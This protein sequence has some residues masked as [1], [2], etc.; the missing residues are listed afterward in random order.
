MTG[1]LTGLLTKVVKGGGVEITLETFD[2]P[3]IDVTAV[4]M[5]IIGVNLGMTG[6]FRGDGR[7]L[8]LCEPLTTALATA[9]AAVAVMTLGNDD[10]DDDNTDDDERD[11]EGGGIG[12]GAITGIFSLVGDVTNAVLG[13]GKCVGLSLVS[14]RGNK[15]FFAGLSWSELELD[16]DEIAE[17]G[18]VGLPWGDVLTSS[19]PNLEG[20]P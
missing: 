1:K 6:D 19:L 2:E 15:S 17:S 16:P 14:R 12:I 7:V 3:M 8:M 10:D 20:R 5:V 4:G 11:D 18:D 9:T 13:K